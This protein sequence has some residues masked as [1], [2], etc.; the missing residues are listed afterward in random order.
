[1]NIHLIRAAE[2]VLSGGI[3]AYPT[4]GVFGLGCL[5]EDDLAVARLLAIKKRS[6]S[7]G[8]ILIA[9]DREQFVGWVDDVAITQIPAPDP[10]FPITWIAPPG[11]KVTPIIRGIH[12]GVAV[13][14]CTHSSAAALCRLVDS[15][16]T[17]T[18]ANLSGQPIVRN[19]HQLRRHFLTLVD[20]IVPGDCGPST[21]ASEIRQLTSGKVLRSA[22]T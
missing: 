18:S 4:E 7:K 12:P 16:L 14:I 2:I 3:V 1:M 5:P 15:P 8:I 9:A 11:P 6:A 22:T 21:G 10:Q 20:Y 19:K 13:R 17:S